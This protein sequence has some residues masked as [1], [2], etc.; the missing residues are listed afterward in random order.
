MSEW[1]SYMRISVWKGER[2]R[3]GERGREREREGERDR[4]RER[5]WQ[6]QR[7]TERET[8]TQTGI[9]C[10][11]PPPP[12]SNLCWERKQT[13]T[14][15]AEV[16]LWLTVISHLFHALHFRYVELQHVLNAVLQRDNGAGAAGAGPL[17][18]QADDAVLKPLCNNQCLH[19]VLSCLNP[20]AQTRMHSFY[21]SLWC[22]Y[23]Y[24]HRHTCRTKASLTKLWVTIIHNTQHILGN[25]GC[26]QMC[27]NCADHVINIK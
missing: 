21:A 11:P 12:P 27:Q 24:T 6:W 25:T 23:I 8:E 17:H 15:T 1:I 4:D 3:E 13:Q 16:H 14:T 10:N 18:L 20:R 19:F 26:K 22:I 7:D 5:E 2:E 9:V